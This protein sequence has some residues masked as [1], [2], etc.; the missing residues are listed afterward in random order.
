[1]SVHS[2]RSELLDKDGELSEQHSANHRFNLDLDAPVQLG[3]PA[4]P[5]RQKWYDL[6]GRFKGKRDLYRYLVYEVRVHTRNKIDR[7]HGQS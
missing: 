4:D 5:D 7:G 1:M 3:Q 6:M 2:E